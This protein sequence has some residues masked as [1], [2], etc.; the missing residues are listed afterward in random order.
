MYFTNAI[1]NLSRHHLRT[2]IL[3]I[4]L[5]NF[6]ILEVMILVHCVYIR[7]YILIFLKNKFKSLFSL[8]LN[9][10]IEQILKIDIH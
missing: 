4:I 2:L 9:I 3:M 5:S 10:N 1:Y 8:K 6:L 7:L